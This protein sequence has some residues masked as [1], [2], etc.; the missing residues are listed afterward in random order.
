MSIRVIPIAVALEP[1]GNMS[2]SVIIF[3]SAVEGFNMIP[4]GGCGCVHRGLSHL[5]DISPDILALAFIPEPVVST[6]VNS[7][8][9]IRNTSEM[10]E[11][12][13]MPSLELHSHTFPA[14]MHRS[15]CEP[16]PATLHF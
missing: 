6:E 12:T 15:S 4:T 5:L 9:D 3:P 10:L 7:I 13:S 2:V 8:L 14:N 1:D 11:A 16:S